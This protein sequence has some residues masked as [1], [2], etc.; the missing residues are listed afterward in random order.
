MHE[1]GLPADDFCL[2]FPVEE[3]PNVTHYKRAYQTAL[4]MRTIPEAIVAL[5]DD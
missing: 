5:Q 4:T 2:L 3:R 1:Y